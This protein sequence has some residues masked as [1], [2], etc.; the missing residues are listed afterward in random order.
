MQMIESQTLWF[1]RL[2]KFEDPLEGL[3]TDA[4]LAGIRQH[5]EKHLAEQL[6]ALFRDAR[7]DTYVSC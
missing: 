4:E 5:V 1:S 6:I 2:D 7:K 3:H